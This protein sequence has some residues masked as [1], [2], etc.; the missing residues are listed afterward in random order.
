MAL[1]WL[2]SGYQFLLPEATSCIFSKNLLFELGFGVLGAST[3][4]ILRVGGMLPAG[5]SPEQGLW[6]LFC[7]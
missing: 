2:L 3:A 5:S 4:N 6:G 1:A 7:G